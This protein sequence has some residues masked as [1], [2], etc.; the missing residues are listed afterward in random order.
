MYS[1]IWGTKCSTLR[2]GKDSWAVIT[3]ATGGLGYETAFYLADEGFSIIIIANNE[4][5]LEETRIQL[6]NKYPSLKIEIYLFDFA[7]TT[8]IKDYSELY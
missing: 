6:L 4:S 3:G 7:Q 1:A 8:E 5:K 2:Y